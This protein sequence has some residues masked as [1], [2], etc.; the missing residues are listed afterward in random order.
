M[1]FS[2]SVAPPVGAEVSLAR[3]RARLLSL[4]NDFRAAHGVRLLREDPDLDLMAQR[5]SARMA[6][7]RTLFHTANLGYKL[8]SYSVWGENLGYGPRLRQVFRLWTQS[9]SHRE[10]LLDRR[11]RWV[12]IG[13]VY[14]RGVFWVTIIFCG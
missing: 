2:A 5:H 7:A 14:S 8:R 9:T 3:A 10:N 13:V 1:T 12:G 11:F 6:E 4:T